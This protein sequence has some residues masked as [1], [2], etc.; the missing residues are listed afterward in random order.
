MNT[1]LDY[2][3]HNPFEVIGT[4]LSLFYIYCSVNEKIATWI[5]GFSAAIFFA[6]VFW[7][8]KF[9][10][11]LTLQFYYIFI[12]IYGFWNWKFGKNKTSENQLLIIKTKKQQWL[13]LGLSAALIFAVYFIVLKRFTDS[14]VPFGDSLATALCIV[15]TWMLTQKLLENWLVFIVSDGIGMALYFSQGLYFT[16]FL[17]AVYTLMAIVGFFKWRKNTNRK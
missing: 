5:F 8:S 11:G 4:I 15:G 10:A 6:V 14:P 2:I 13:V 1:I 7:Q 12:S 17:F 16:A 9:Y 3:S